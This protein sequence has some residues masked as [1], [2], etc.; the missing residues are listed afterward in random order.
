MKYTINGFY[1]EKLVELGLDVLDSTILE[2]L[3][4]LAAAPSTVVHYEGD[5]R[6]FWVK[7]GSLINALPV[8]GIKKRA[9]GRR[10]KK[11]VKCGL[12]YLHIDKCKKGTFSMYC[13]DDEVY[14]PMKYGKNR[15][16]EILS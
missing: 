6:F 14:T 12:L 3:V 1:Q 5:K 11:Y 10:M 7:Y 9:L 13:F 8:L 15:A 2:Y 4:D 16:R